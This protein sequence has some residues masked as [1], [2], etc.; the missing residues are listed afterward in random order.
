MHT[1]TRF[2]AFVGAVVLSLAW[3]SAASADC[4][5]A[6]LTGL[7]PSSAAFRDQPIRPRA[8]ALQYDDIAF[9][10]HRPLIVGLWTVTLVADGA[11][12]DVAFDAWHADGT[13][14]LNDAS[15][16]SHN[17]CLGVW[18]QTGRRTFQLKH[19]AFRFDAAGNVIGALV[20]RETNV[21]N[22]AGDRFTGTFTIQF[23]DLTGVLV[24]EGSGQI[25]GERVTVD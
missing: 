2:T 20:L 9:D 7:A 25:V 21:V 23:F 15:P 4:G 12:I 13:E 1:A 10:D 24:F 22:V 14:T 11:V 8:V 18:A 5:G 19:P 3:P 16:V 17:V 6:A